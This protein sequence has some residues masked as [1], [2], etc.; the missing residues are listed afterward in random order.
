MNERRI[1]IADDDPDLLEYFHN[2]FERDNSLNFFEAEEPPDAFQVTT[3]SDGAPLVDFFRT[4]HA[5]GRRIPICLLDMRMPTMDGLTAAEALRSIDPEVF[6]VILTAYADV[7]AAEIRSR[8]ACRTSP[9]SWNDG[10]P[11]PFSSTRAGHGRLKPLGSWRQR[12]IPST[13]MES[14]I[15][16]KGAIPIGDLDADAPVFI[17]PRASRGVIGIR[18]RQASPSIQTSYSTNGIEKDSLPS[19]HSSAPSKKLCRARHPPN[20]LEGDQRGGTLRNKV[21]RALDSLSVHSSRGHS[22]YRSFG[23]T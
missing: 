5:E 23:F 2:I 3:F 11:L 13:V 18:R 21:N 9:P 22:V 17:A 16:R 10:C 19:R 4:E 20:P 8:S 15:T 14:A 6:I 7:S 12:K 1:V